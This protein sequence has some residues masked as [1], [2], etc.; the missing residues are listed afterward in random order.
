MT[1]FGLGPSAAEEL[2]A[3]HPD[4]LIWRE[5]TEEGRH[6]LWMARRHDA[7]REVEA[8]TIDELSLKLQNLL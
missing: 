4:W 8:Y 6:G 5:Q 2:Q 1:T 3:D 7:T